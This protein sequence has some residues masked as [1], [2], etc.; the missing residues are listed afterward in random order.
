MS[1]TKKSIL[2]SFNRRQLLEEA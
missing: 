2:V 1:T